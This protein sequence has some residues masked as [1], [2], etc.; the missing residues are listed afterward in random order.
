MKSYLLNL[1]RN[2]VWI[3]SGSCAKSLSS[4]STSSTS[5]GKELISMTCIHQKSRF[6]LI[7][8]KLV[9]DQGTL[10]P[11]SVWIFFKILSDFGHFQSQISILSTAS[12]MCWGWGYNKEKGFFVQ[13]LV[14]LGF[15]SKS[16]PS[17]LR[18]TMLIQNG[19]NEQINPNPRS[20]F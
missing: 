11:I 4:A 3:W 1:L 16:F 14:F 18:F 15:Q 2:L 17:E 19:L 7:F 6:G 5:L 10:G 13:A 8:V 20:F 12:P 9:R